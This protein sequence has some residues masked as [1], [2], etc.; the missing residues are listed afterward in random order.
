MGIWGIM[1]ANFQ[2]IGKQRDL[3]AA[4][5]A[6]DK[7]KVEQ[8]IAESISTILKAGLSSRQLTALEEIE[9]KEGKVLN[10]ALS[11]AFHLGWTR[12]GKPNLS[13]AMDEVLR[14]AQELTRKRT[15]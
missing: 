10:K 6:D 12:D 13:N 4:L 1:K 2:A 14:E 9:K 11:D 8:L 15:N 3:E 7:P 5:A